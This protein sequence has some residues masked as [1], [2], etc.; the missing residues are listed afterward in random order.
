MKT[1]LISFDFRGDEQAMS[2]LA[3]VLNKYCGVRFKYDE[4]IIRAD[5]GQEQLWD[6]INSAAGDNAYILVSE[7]C[8]AVRSRQPQGITGWI[9]KNCH[10]D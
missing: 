3:G 8:G 1:F 10:I 5:I 2:E 9:N 7:L 6:E 4:W